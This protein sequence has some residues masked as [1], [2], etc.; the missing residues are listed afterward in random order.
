L[1]HAGN[2]RPDVLIFMS[3]WTRTMP[4]ISFVKP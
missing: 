3:G 4:R 2:R 1:G